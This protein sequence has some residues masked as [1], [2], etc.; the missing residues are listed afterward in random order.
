MRILFY[1][2]DSYGMG[3]IRRTVNVAGRLLREFPQVSGL[4]LTGAPRAHYFTYPPG[5][6]YIK[7]PSV[8]KNDRGDY[9]SLDLELSLDDTVSLR[10]GVISSVAR[11]FVPDLVLV[12]HTPRGLCGEV[13]PLLQPQRTG[14]RQ[15][16]RV[17]GLRDVIDD[18]GRVRKSWQ[19]TGV[20]EVLRSAYDRILVY[21]QQDIFD[22]AQE[23]ELPPEVERKIVYTGF[24]TT[25]LETAPDKGEAL[26]ATHAPRTGRL[27]TVTAGGG[28]DG[29]PLMRSMLRA[30]RALGP[31]PPFE[32][33][34]VS[35]P[36]L[37]PRKRKR[38]AEQVRNLEGVSLLE[39]SPDLPRLYA[40]S[41]LAVT[42]GGY[43]TVCELAAVGA[44]ALIAPRIHPRLEQQ[45]RADRLARRGVVDVLPPGIDDPS[46]LARILL[47]AL[48]RPRPPRNWQLDLQGLDRIGPYL[49]GLLRTR[50]PTAAWDDQG[51]AL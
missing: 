17:L 39:F 43:N 16:I 51:A 31:Q 1:S 15:P 13:L 22:V 28:G 48:D 25:P 8:T 37:S 50:R 36:L 6:D 23:Y 14:N 44:R 35:G 2:H 18:P 47:E 49:A 40:I 41:A 26:L 30:Y 24:V 3:H 45:V 27:V 12:D 32:L 42:M 29:L 34:L 19:A 11:S 7:L 21:G 20:V 4:V 5:C 9:V 33:L 10:R 38:L 46:R